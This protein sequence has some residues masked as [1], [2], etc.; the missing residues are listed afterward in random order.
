[1]ED[2]S[3]LLRRNLGVVFVTVPL[4]LFVFSKLFPDRAKKIKQKCGA[5]IIDR[6]MLSVHSKC[7]QEKTDLFKSFDLLKVQRARVTF[8][9][10][11]GH[12]M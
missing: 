9:L 2:A 3:F 6:V 4:G 5:W 8:G 10:H 11:R 12:Y 7:V 1:M